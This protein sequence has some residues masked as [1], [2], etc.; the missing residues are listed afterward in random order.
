MLEVWIMRHGEAVDPD[1]A[2]VDSERQLT[3][4]GRQQVGG[5]ARWLREHAGTPERY[6]HSP[7]V[8]ARQTAAVFADEYVRPDQ[9]QLFP[10]LAPGMNSERLLSALATTTWSTVLCVGHQPDI[11]RCVS[12]MI[13]GG[14]FVIPPGFCAAITFSGPVVGGAGSLKWV[15]NPE[16][17]G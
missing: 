3:T 13:G 15:T 11:G 12:E 14:R 9:L 6:L 7:L 17:F 10:S 5:L 4:T 1:Q 16:W 2:T 8:R